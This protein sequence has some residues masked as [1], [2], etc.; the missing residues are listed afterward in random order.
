MATY[1]EPEKAGIGN[2]GTVTIFKQLVKQNMEDEKI[3][4]WKWLEMT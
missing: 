1:I 4:D 3:L 2:T